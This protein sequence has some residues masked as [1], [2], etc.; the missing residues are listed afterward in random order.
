MRLGGGTAAADRPGRGRAP[1][2]S[3]RPRSPQAPGGLLA[4]LLVPA[5]RRALVIGIIGAVLLLVVGGHIRQEQG[6]G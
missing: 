4:G 3:P 1:T 5:G 6:F 2:G